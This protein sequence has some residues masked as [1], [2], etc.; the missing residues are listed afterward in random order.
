MH[1]DL[2]D[3]ET[4]FIHVTWLPYV[5]PSK[6]L[7]TKPTQHSVKELR[8]I[9]IQPDVIV[10]RSDQPVPDELNDKIALFC[11]VEKRGVVPLETAESIYEVPLVLEEAGLAD[12]VVE[13][14]AL[15]AQP[16]AL[17]EWRV[18]VQK[19][20]GGRGCL[21][22]GVVGKYVGLEDSY[23]SVREALHHAGW[24]HDRRLKLEWI[25]SSLL[26]A[27]DGERLLEGLD[28]IVVPGGFGYRGV[29][30]K[31]RAARYARQHGVPYLG[32]CLGM[33]V[34]CIEFARAVL[35]DEDAN[36]TEFNLFSRHPVIDLLPEQ[37]DVA[38]KGGTMRLG[39]YPCQLVPGSR[40]AAAYQQEIVFERHRHRF[41]FNNDY[42]ERLSTAG[43]VFSGLSPDGRLV[44]IAELAH[45]PW[46]LGTQFH[47]EL[48]SRPNRSHPL[49][50]DFIGACKAR[51]GHAENGLASGQP[52]GIDA[53]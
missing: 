51:A 45:H 33:Q 14:L 8:S 16:A 15:S 38:D 17:D 34:M 4:F 24:F 27:D 5:G 18:L 40:A 49:F 7:K 39:A 42:R 47:P 37:K 29:E 36:S 21:R 1:R 2:G 48:K 25:D 3:A 19:A 11:D 35:G 44:E 26:E 28:G 10:A 6:E 23:I 43:L 31:I 53:G 12:F 20:K 41:E 9:G 22:V 50:R 46:M 30:G 32:L 52:V 13:R